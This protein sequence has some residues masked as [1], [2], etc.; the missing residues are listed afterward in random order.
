MCQVEHN[1]PETYGDCVS[2]CIST[3]IDRDDVPHVYDGNCS[4]EEAWAELREYLKIHKK[5]MVFFLSEN[6]FEQMAGDNPDIIYMMLCTTE[7][8]TT[9]AVVCMGDNIIHDPSHIKA[10]ELRPILA[11][12]FGVIIVGEF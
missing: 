2:A 10:R 7:R 9:H 8:S 6:P 1:P 12:Q 3:M 5:N 4:P 11:D